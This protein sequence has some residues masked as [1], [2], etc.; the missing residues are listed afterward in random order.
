MDGPRMDIQ[1]LHCVWPVRGRELRCDANASDASFV[2]QTTFVATVAATP[3]QTATAEPRAPF[4][5][6]ASRTTS[7][8]S[9][10]AQHATT[11]HPATSATAV[12]ARATSLPS[13]G[14]PVLNDDWRGRHTSLLQLEFI[15]RVVVVL[16]PRRAGPEHG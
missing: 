14:S 13:L 9:F 1:Q 2:A 6:L 8:A 3:T 12:A 5:S 16:L 10:T 4:T 11:A 15:Q 7:C